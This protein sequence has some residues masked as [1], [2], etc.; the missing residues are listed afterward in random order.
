MTP[1]PCP[2]EGK[3]R[4]WH[5]MT[6]SIKCPI[7]VCLYSFC[8]SFRGQGGEW[9]IQRL[10]AENSTCSCTILRNNIDHSLNWCAGQYQSQAILKVSTRA[11]WQIHWPMTITHQWCQSIDYICWW[12]IGA[13]SHRSTA[14]R[15]HEM[16]LYRQIWIPGLFFSKQQN[17]PSN[18]AAVSIGVYDTQMQPGLQLKYWA[19][20]ILYACMLH[21]SL[22]VTCCYRCKQ[23][24]TNN[25][26]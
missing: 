25:Y 16:K 12:H 8:F 24:C 14:P 21:A 1:C 7:F 17:A 3:T 15:K 5:P 19:G 6:N 23:D 4:F 13:H 11:T 26:S 10:N 9:G 18:V 2:S 22:S 20:A